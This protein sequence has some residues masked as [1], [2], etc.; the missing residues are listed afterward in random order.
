MKVIYFSKERP[1]GDTVLIK[2]MRSLEMK[3]PAG[4]LTDSLLE[5]N[6]IILPEMSLDVGA[7]TPSCAT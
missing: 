5:L 4:L 1:G 6:H 7:W 3:G 2:D